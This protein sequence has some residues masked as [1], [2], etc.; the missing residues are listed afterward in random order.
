MD[1]DYHTL[2]PKV[3]KGMYPDQAER[4]RVERMLAAYGNESYHREK[5]RVWLGILYLSSKQPEKQASFVKLACTDYRDLLCA[6]EYPYSSKH[7]SLKQ[8]DPDNYLKLQAQEQEE[9]QA[10]LDSFMPA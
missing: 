2:V 7:W 9:Y 5:D 8:K 10:W 6:A 4:T 3:L 1:I